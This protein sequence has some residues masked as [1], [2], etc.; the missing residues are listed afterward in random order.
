MTGS[1]AKEVS[2]RNQRG[3]G[4]REERGYALCSFSLTHCF[5]KHFLTISRTSKKTPAG[6]TEV[7]ILLTQLLFSC[8]LTVSK[9]NNAAGK[10]SNL[11]RNIS[12]HINS[13]AITLICSR[14][15]SS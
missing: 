5:F 2:D 9:T 4:K 15:T 6:N 3:P 7:L 13:I 11:E 12:I 14:T 10:N 8:H 1:I